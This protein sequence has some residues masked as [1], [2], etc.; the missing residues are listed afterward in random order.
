MK[1]PITW[2]DYTVMSNPNGVML[3][4][5]K[6]G[7]IGWMAP[8]DPNELYEAACNLIQQYGDQGVEDLL[9]AHPDFEII[10]QIPQT[11]QYKGFIDSLFNNVVDKTPSKNIIIAG[12]FFLLAYLI[13]R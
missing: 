2:L 11:S 13:L 5:A 1:K 9:R 7:F 12:A 10:R 6:Y 3:V 8:Q 4:L